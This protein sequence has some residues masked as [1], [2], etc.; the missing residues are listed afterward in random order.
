METYILLC[1]Q[2]NAKVGVEYKRDYLFSNAALDVFKGPTAS[3]DFAVGAEGFVAGAEVSYNV[4][5]GKVS[6]YASALGYSTMDYSVALHGLNNLTAFSAS[7]FHRVSP[8]I[9]AGARAVWDKKNVG[10]NVALEVGGKYA[11]DKVTF[12]KAKINNAGILGL[13]LT[14]SVRPGVKVTLGGSFDTAKLNDNAHKL[15]FSLALEA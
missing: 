12:A 15:G 14:Q 10:G 3:A 9:E 11:F 8:D 4:Q 5:E 7:Y 13:G 6:R 1:S 2:K